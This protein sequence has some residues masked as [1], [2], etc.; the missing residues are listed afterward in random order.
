[1]YCKLVANTFAIYCHVFMQHAG[2]LKA[3]V[4]LWSWSVH[5]SSQAIM[6]NNLVLCSHFLGCTKLSTRVRNQRTSHPIAVAME[7]DWAVKRNMSA[8]NDGMYDKFNTM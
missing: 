1:M 6:I 4:L 7:T 3:L 2:D 5:T 8:V